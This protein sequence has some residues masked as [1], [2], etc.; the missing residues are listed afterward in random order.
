MISGDCSQP[1]LSMECLA[2]KHKQHTMIYTEFCRL[3]PW[4]IVCDHR[5]IQ[6]FVRGGGQGPL[7]PRL[8]IWGSNILWGGGGGGN[9]PLAP[10]GS[11]HG[12][13]GV[14]ARVWSGLY[15]VCVECMGCV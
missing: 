1:Q 6:D 10:P 15:C 8:T 9:A 12:D 5:R 7:G 11:A 14:C 3:Q 13:V 4:N 2:T